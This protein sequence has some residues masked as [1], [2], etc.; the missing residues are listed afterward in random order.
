VRKLTRSS[1]L[2]KDMSSINKPVQPNEAKPRAPAK[3][4]RANE[5]PAQS[6][7]KRE[8][9]IKNNDVSE[10]E[11]SKI[12]DFGFEKPLR[13]QAVEDN[14]VKQSPNVMIGQFSSSAV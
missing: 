6:D 9:T 10:S 11:G 14:K 8:Q 1:G 5:T 2:T 7:T 13:K 12:G 3:G 4:I